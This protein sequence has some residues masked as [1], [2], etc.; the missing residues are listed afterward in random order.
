MQAAAR[1]TLVSLFEELIEE[2]VAPFDKDLG[3]INDLIPQ[4]DTAYS[5][6]LRGTKLNNRTL[7]AAL[8]RLGHSQLTMINYIVDGI[9]KTA[10]VW[11]WRNKEK[12]EAATGQEIAVAM[13]L[14]KE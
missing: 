7:P 8:E 4:L 11:C 3:R 14:A 6:M 10:R 5:A 12:W 9:W 13:G 1:G 2:G